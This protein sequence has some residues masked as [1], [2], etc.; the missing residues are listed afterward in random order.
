MRERASLK[1]KN[2]SIFSWA[3]TKHQWGK[4][5]GGENQ[6]ARVKEDRRHHSHCER[7]EGDISK[8]RKGGKPKNPQKPILRLGKGDYSAW[9]D[10]RKRGKKKKTTSIG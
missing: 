10:P 8:R 6:G 1:K 9:G 7:Q 2:E 4:K 3:N 5:R